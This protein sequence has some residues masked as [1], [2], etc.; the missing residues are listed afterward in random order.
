MAISANNY[1]ICMTLNWSRYIA[2]G[3]ATD[4]SGFESQEGQEFY[5]SISSRQALR[6]TQPP[7]E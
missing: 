4:G 7:I 3:I 1:W 5:S 2:V 6:S